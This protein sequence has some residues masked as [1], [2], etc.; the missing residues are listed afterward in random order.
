MARA[1]IDFIARWPGVTE[2]RLVEMLADPPTEQL[3]RETVADL[4]REGVIVKDEKGGYH[5]VGL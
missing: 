1:V 3:L 2:D 4:V 5:A